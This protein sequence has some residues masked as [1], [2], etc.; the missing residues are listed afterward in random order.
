MI[1]GAGLTTADFAPAFA[2][3]ASQPPPTDQPL[4]PAGARPATRIVGDGGAFDA[5]GITATN[6]AFAELSQSVRLTS[7]AYQGATALTANQLRATW[8]D[9]E[10]RSVP[11][12][13]LCRVRDRAEAMF[14][15]EG[16]SFVV[17][18]IADQEIDPQNSVV[19]FS[20]REP[21]I[22]A[23]IIYQGDFG[24]A[25]AR[26]EKLLA[27]LAGMGPVRTD[28][29]E[30]ALVLAREIPGLNISLSLRR[31]GA[32]SDTLQIVARAVRNSYAAYA[33]V[34]RLNAPE[35]GR[36]AGSLTGAVAG[37]TPYGDQIDGSIYTSET[38]DQ[39][40]ATLGG[41]IVYDEDITFR[42]QVSHV[43]TSPGGSI[44]PLQIEGTATKV[45]LS[46]AKPLILRARQRVTASAGFEYVDQKNDLFGGQ[47]SL[48]TDKLRI[49]K[50]SLAGELTSRPASRG[51]G[52]AYAVRGN[53]ELRQGID[54]LD[55]SQKGEIDISRT[56]GDTQAMVL[57]ANAQGI[58]RPIEQVGFSLEL[59][60]QW[61][62]DALLAPE[63][64]QAGNYTVG[65]GYLPGALSGDEAIG[66]K[67]EVQGP[68]WT[69]GEFQLGSPDARP[70]GAQ[71]Y[72][73]YDLATI[74]SQSSGAN[75]RTLSSYG[76]GVR[77]RMPG[78][79]DLD[80]AW[81]KPE[82]AVVQGGPEPSDQFNVIFST[83][84]R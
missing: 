79:F 74:S 75:E 66:G 14:E 61:S 2:Q 52:S 24:P 22:S 19:T 34:Q 30:R 1:V 54:V 49:V 56:D 47:Q 42:G 60:G 81:A 57:R 39:T 76:I 67:F 73:F 29:F 65:R 13:A 72:I 26:I 62:G 37:L 28:A 69:L 6:C 59:M 4:G 23:E 18:D 50:A 7:V 64:F 11:I 35:F 36:W 43:R 70:L 40:Y 84:L 63:Q 31:S 21:S 48:F 77:F 5:T 68:T 83:K 10:G 41:Q 3:V 16:Y 45:D 33:G 71:P 17:V 27:P 44:A 55:A 51:E 58:Y 78:A 82:R 32:K 80:L 20:V 25:K 9:Y 8:S 46:V 53:I 38:G 12:A 15:N